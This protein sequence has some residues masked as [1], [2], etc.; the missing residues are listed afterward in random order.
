MTNHLRARFV[1]HLARNFGSE[2]NT[3]SMGEGWPDLIF[4]AAFGHHPNVVIC[5]FFL[6]KTTTMVTSRYVCLENTRKFLPS[7]FLKL[8]SLHEILEQFASCKF[9]PC[10]NFA[11][12]TSLSNR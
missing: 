8:Y 6:E 2:Q 5:F 12:P 3:N 7:K 4:L 9:S 1:A 11:D 10:M